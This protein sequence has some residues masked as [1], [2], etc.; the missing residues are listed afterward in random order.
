MSLSRVIAAFG[1]MC[2]WRVVLP[3]LALHA[4]PASADPLSFDYR[5]GAEPSLVA[6]APALAVTSPRAAA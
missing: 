6:G 3:I 1:R 4:L 2:S 5:C